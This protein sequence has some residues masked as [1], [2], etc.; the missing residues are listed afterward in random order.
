MNKHIGTV[1]DFLPSELVELLC[2][3]ITNPEF[4]WFWRE[5]SKYGAMSHGQKDYQFVHNVFYDGNPLSDM[6]PAIEEIIRAFVDTTKIEFVDICRIKINLTTPSTLSVEE[7]NEAIHAD[8]T[9]GGN[10]LSI[11]YYVDDADGDTLLYEDGQILKAQTPKKGTA[12]YFPSHML[13]RHTPP[14]KYKRRLV[15]NFIMK[16]S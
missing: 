5:S 13:H 7:L 3:S 12:F 1:A 15:I 9:T 4:P 16:I 14:T 2:N 10:Y 6:F 11:I 8:I